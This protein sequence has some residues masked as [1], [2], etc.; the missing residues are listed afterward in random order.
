MAGATIASESLM[1]RLFLIWSGMFLL[2]LFVAE[3][4]GIPWLIYIPL[5]CGLIHAL[6][7]A[8]RK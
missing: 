6:A 3:A 1:P 5:V 7:V 4:V 8:S 2:S